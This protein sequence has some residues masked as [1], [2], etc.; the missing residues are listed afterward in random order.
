MRIIIVGGGRTGYHLVQ[1]IPRSIMIEKNPEKYQR[2]N[3]LIGVNAILGDG[4]DEKVLLK[5]GLKEADAVITVTADDKT[6]FEVASISKKYGVRNIIS[7]MENPE[8]E[9]QFKDLDISAILC[10]TTVV[11]DYIKDL[12]HPKAEKEFFIKKILVP[13]IGPMTMEQ[14]FEEALQISLKTDAQLLLLGNKKENLGEEK[15]IVNLLDVPASIE[16]EEG[17]MT[18]AI[19]K[20]SKG[21]DLIVVDPE[22]LS[23][24]EKILKRSIVNR[25]LEKSDTPILISRV[26]KKYNKILLLG[27]SSNALQMAFNIGHLFGEIFNSNIEVMLLEESKDLEE[28]LEKLKEHGKIDGFKVDKGDFEGNVNIEVVKKVKSG[29]FDLT[30]LPWGGSTLLKDDVVDSIINGAPGSVLIIKG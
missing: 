8:N 1:H 25:L 23:Y 18:R 15:K 20:H 21:A 4:S 12:I 3:E 7:R 13:I 16:I 19:E 5:A 6:N 17:D 10:P 9:G 30:I 24:F 2:L 22:E 26:F 11:A 27:D 28:S 29:L 14:A